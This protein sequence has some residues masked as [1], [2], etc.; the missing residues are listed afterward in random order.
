MDTF[1]EDWNEFNNI[2]KVIIWQQ[3]HTEYKVTFPHL[4]NSLP[5]SVRLSPYHSP[6]KCISASTILTCPR[7]TSIHSSIP[8]LC[9]DSHR[10]MHHSSRA[11]TLSLARMTLMTTSLSSRRIYHRS[12][13]KSLSRMIW[14]QTASPSGGPLIRT[15]VDRGVWGVRRTFL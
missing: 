1:D 14:R 15:T 13:R 11:K 6:K 12:S 5:R 10:K 2:G 3:I 8:F 4:Y 9:A 7:S